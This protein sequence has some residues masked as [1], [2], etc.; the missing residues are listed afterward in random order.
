MIKKRFLWPFLIFVLIVVASFYTWKKIDNSQRTV[1]PIRGDIIESIYGLGVVT[2]DE[3]FHLRTGVPLT[4]QKLY[5][6]E[7]DFVRSRQALMQLD[8]HTMRSP[9]EGTV[10]NVTYKLGEIV[11][12]LINALTVTNMDRLYLEVNLEQQSVMRVRT[13]QE[14]VISFESLRNVKYSGLVKSI[15]PRDS[16]FI[17][18]IELQK[19]P[20]GVL[21]GMTADTAILVGKK[22]N[23]LLIPLKTIVAGHVTRYRDG[24]KQ[25]IPVEL[26]IVDGEWAEVVSDNLLETDQLVVRK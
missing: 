8:D 20:E 17:I 11:S 6:K 9:I 24:K 21:L 14:V 4:V 2:G 5:V 10:T 19:W 12:P 16:Q 3:I 7:G 15:F 25:R 18:R 22:K 1:Q 13:S 23:T 26:G